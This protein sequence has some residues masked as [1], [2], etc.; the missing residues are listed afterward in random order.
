MKEAVCWIWKC[1]LI[2][3]CLLPAVME[4]VKPPPRDPTRK[5][6]M[7]G[8]M[9]PEHSLNHQQRWETE[10][11]EVLRFK[12]KSMTLHLC[13]LQHQRSSNDISWSLLLSSKDNLKRH[14]KVKQ[15]VLISST[16]THLLWFNTSLSLSMCCPNCLIHYSEERKLGYSHDFIPSYC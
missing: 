13:L 9:T 16:I 3:P 10:N 1:A 12:A 15:S 7:A 4:E 14:E 5:L 8:E 11:G 2:N 6:R